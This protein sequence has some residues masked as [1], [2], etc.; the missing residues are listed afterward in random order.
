MPPTTKADAAEAVRAA[1]SGSARGIPDR[2]I[3]RETGLPFRDVKHTL[4]ALQ[5]E[6]AVEKVSGRWRLVMDQPS[7]AMASPKGKQQAAPEGFDVI[8]RVC[9]FHAAVVKEVAASKLKLEPDDSRLSEEVVAPVNWYDLAKGKTAIL[10]SDLPSSQWTSENRV[11]F[12]G[13]LH[14]VQKTKRGKPAE[15]VWLPVFLLHAKT[16]RRQDRI[17]FE[18]DGPVEVNLEWLDEVSQ[19]ADEDLRNDLLIRLGLLEETRDGEPKPLQVSNFEDCWLA[20]LKHVPELTWHG[21]RDLRS[22]VQ[23]ANLSQESRVGIYPRVLLFEENLG[24]YNK[25][26]I[27]DLRA[28]S[29]ASDEEI[30]RSAL[31]SL[32][33]NDFPERTFSSKEPDVLVHWDKAWCSSSPIPKEARPFLLKLLWNCSMDPF[34]RRIRNF[35]MPFQ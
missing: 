33:P 2:T 25:G 30:K 27:E 34:E 6:N 18:L 15:K 7:P 13:P 5:A 10:R 19:K 29:E 20:L 12:S 31:P 26:L 32:F 11:V 21:S 3:Q 8:R 17:E 28:I 9:S 1:L 16:H 22:P 35:R 23:P 24:S 4:A 14:L